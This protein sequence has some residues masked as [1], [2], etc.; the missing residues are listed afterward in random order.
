M[1]ILRHS[2]LEMLLW[3]AYGSIYLGHFCR[4]SLWRCFYLETLL[5]LSIW[6]AS[7]DSFKDTFILRRFCRDSFEDASIWISWRCFCLEDASI[8]ISWRHF[9]LDFLVTLLSWW[10]FYLNFLEILLSWFLSDASFLKMLLP[11]FFSDAPVLKV[12]LSWFLSFLF[13]FFFFREQACASFH[14]AY[15][16]HALVYACSERSYASL[17][18]VTYSKQFS[19]SSF[20]PFHFLRFLSVFTAFSSAFSFQNTKFFSFIIMSRR[21]GSR[22]QSNAS[23]SSNTAAMDL[24]PVDDHFSLN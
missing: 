5:A 10:C 3:D 18:L 22:G 19:N 21:L 4:F 11:W 7:V 1:T 20:A 15:A 16:S 9:C 8:W 6:A 12:L 13:F 23:S 2:S 24:Y 14:G 17:A